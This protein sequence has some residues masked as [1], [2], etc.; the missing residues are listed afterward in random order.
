M[1]LSAQSLEHCDGFGH[2]AGLSKNV[3]IDG[4]QR[5]SRDNNSFR[6][7]PRRREGLSDCVERGQLPEG[8]IRIKPFPNIRRPGFEFESS[9]C[10]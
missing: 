4:N 9:L 6:M 10:Q 5:V 7:I 3:F 1:G 2:I 8:E